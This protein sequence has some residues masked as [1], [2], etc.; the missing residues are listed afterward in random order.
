MVFSWQSD[1]SASSACVSFFSIIAVLIWAR[2]ASRVDLDTLAFISAA[3]PEAARLRTQFIGIYRQFSL[4]GKRDRRPT[5]V[6]WMLGVGRLVFPARRGQ[7]RC[8]SDARIA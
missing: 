7:F 3:C 8:G 1:A 4:R 5:Y 2:A 6:S